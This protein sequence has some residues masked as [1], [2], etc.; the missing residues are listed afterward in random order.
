MIDRLSLAGKVAIVTGAAGGVG[1]ETVALLAARG[2]RIVAEDLDPSVHT[3]KTE[4]VAV[5]E[6][7]VRSADSA[8]AAVALAVAQFGGVDLLVNN[9]AVILSKDILAT[10]PAEWEM[11]MAVNVTGVYFHCRAV[12]PQ[13]ISKGLGAIVNV[14]S[15]SGV[16]GLPQQAAYCA[17][18]GAVVQLTRQLAV[19]YAA[20][21][22][23]VNAVAPGAIDTPFLERHLAAQ[24][25]RAEAE[26]AV[27]AAHPLGRYA[28]PAEIAE[29]IAFLGS[30][31]ASF[32]TG[33][34]L[35]AD[36]GYT[37]R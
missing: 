5:L 22:I 15:I 11:V 34:I 14:T 31:A 3:L 21:G 37:A 19:E 12:L 2:A 1:R 24:P 20:A 16:L 8:E 27:N 36:G 30:D 28:A 17:S 26:R 4:H 9:A 7:D 32:V 13:M 10:T 33:A 18:K 6:R 23:R 25:D 35:A 29:T